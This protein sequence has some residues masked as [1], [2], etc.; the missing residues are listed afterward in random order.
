MQKYKIGWIGTGVMGNA[1]CGHL[2][3]AGCQLAVFNRTSSKA[4]NL[5]S[6]GARWCESPVDVADLSDV[7]FS[8]VGF[9]NDVEQV[10]LGDQGVLKTAKPGTILVDMT[11][12]SPELA[13]RIDAAA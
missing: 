13:R 8:M 2:L 11:T 5:I 9:P 6:K 7:I 4:E 12:S 3:D 10:L 1:M